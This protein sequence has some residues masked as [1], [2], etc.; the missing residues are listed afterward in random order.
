MKKSFISMQQ[1]KNS[2]WRYILSL[3]SI[4]FFM[5]LSG[6]AYFVLLFVIEPASLDTPELTLGNP[7]LDLALSHIDYLFW[8]MGLWFSMKVILK[9]PFRTLITPYRKINWKRIVFGFLIFFGLMAISSIVEF[10]VFPNNFTLHDF[11]ISNYIWLLLIALLLVPIQTTCEE[12]VFRGFILQWLGKGLKNPILL[13]IIVGGIFGSLHFANPEMS[14]GALFVGFDYVFT[15][16]MLTYI[17][18]KSNSAELSIGA[19]AANNVFLALFF[20]SDNDVFGEI[21]SL[22][23]VLDESPF[24]SAL[25]S[26][27]IIITFYVITVKT[28]FGKRMNNEGNRI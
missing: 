5:I 13:S 17:A 22:F 2:N 20:T 24:Y 28:R 9:R 26:S 14:D 3:L 4:F 18:V 12:L 1:G 23:V 8:L 11:N 21:P 16:F 10:L 15:G 19:H 6:I 25:M 7:I 27:I